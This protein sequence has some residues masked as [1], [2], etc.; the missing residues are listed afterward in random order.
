MDF[1]LPGR[2]D[3]TFALLDDTR[4]WRQRAVYDIV[5]RDSDHVDASVTYQVLLPIE[6]VRRFEP[7]AAIGDAVRLRLPLT[8]RAKQILLNVGFEGADGHRATL[9]LRSEIAEMQA[10]YLA[11]VDSSP[12]QAQPLGGALWAGVSAMTPFGWRRHAQRVEQQAS[13]TGLP[14]AVA[15]SRHEAMA[16]HLTAELGFH[17]PA[18]SVERWC[19]RSQC[20]RRARS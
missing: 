11:H 2:W 16:A 5:L 8:V 1:D 17:V 19:R 3:L 14:S 18:A 15:S 4:A 13:S 10:H 7:R 12:L 6:L 20:A 9:L